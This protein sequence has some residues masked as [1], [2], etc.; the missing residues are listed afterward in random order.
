MRH[1]REEIVSDEAVGAL[2]NYFCVSLV[3]GINKIQTQKYSTT[4]TST[5]R[6]LFRKCSKK[7]KI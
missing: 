5:L 6:E 2:L 1:H 4:Q 3:W 7:I